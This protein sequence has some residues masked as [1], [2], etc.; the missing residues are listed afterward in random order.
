MGTFVYGS[1]SGIQ[2]KNSRK[3]H[4]SKEWYSTEI[5]SLFII[6]KYIFMSEEGI[7]FSLFNVSLVSF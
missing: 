2:R 5:Y 6:T 1:E 7:Q 3:I 4:H